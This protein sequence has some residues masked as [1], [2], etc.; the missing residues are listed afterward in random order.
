M[1]DFFQ[2]LDASDKAQ[3]IG[4]LATDSA[5]GDEFA[6]HTH[7]Q[8][9]MILSIDGVMIVR[10]DDGSWVVPPGRAVWVPGAYAMAS[11][12]PATCVCAPSSLPME[13][14][15][16]CRAIVVSSA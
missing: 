1:N 8:A 14:A 6:P 11:R 10:T 15:R 2:A 4:V 3:Q 5:A 16:A 7:A 13:S 12:W 9:Q